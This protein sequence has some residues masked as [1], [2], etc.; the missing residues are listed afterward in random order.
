MY[1]RIE[2]ILEGKIENCFYPFFWQ[3][4]E[5][6]AVLRKYMGKIQESGMKAICIEARPHPDFLGEKWW[7][8]LDIIL[9]EARKR[10]MK[11]W[12][13]DDSHFPTGYANGAIKEKYPEHR[14][15]YLYMRRFDVAGPV[16]GARINISYLAGR[17]WDGVSKDINH[18]I[19]VYMAK[20][21]SDRNTGK[22][23]IVVDTLADKTYALKDGIISIDI[24]EGAFCIFTVFYTR[25]GGEET[26]ADYLNPLSAKATQV[27]I[28]TV[29][30]PHYEKYK[31]DFGKTI[32]G[33]F[34]DEPRFGNKKGFLAGIGQDMVLPW[35]LGLEKELPFELKFLPLLWVRGEGLEGE[36]R[37]QY[38]N[39]ITRLYHENFTGVLAKWCHDRGIC[40]LG[41]NIED[42]GAH[43]RLGYGTGHYFRGQT[44]QDF[45][46]IDVIG[47]QIV[48]GMPYHHDSF[49][50]GGCDGEFYHFALA[51][52]GSSAAHLDPVKNGRAM[53]EAFGA[54]GWNEGLKLM[55][56]ITDH[57]V[58]R[59]INYL[60]PHAFSPREFP[61]WDCPPHFYAQG[62]NPQ[63]R[64]FNVYSNYANRLMNLFQSGVHRAPAAVLYPAEQ[65]WAGNYMPVEKPVRELLEHQIDCDIVSADYLFNAVIEGNMLKIH[66][67][68]FKTVIIPYGEAIPVNVIRK[69][70]EYAKSG[71]RV[72]FLNDYP[73]RTL[74][75]ELSEE[76]W[77][78]LKQVCLAGAV[79]DLEVL[80]R[81]LAEIRLE[82]PFR[83]LV[84][85]HYD[86]GT[87]N[88]MFFNEHLSKTVD[89]I[90][91]I[92][93]AAYAYS[94]DAFS[95]TL[96]KLEKK[97]DGYRLK[98][99]PYESCVWIF[100]EDPIAIADE[101]VKPVCHGKPQQLT[102][103]WKVSFADSFS[104]PD[105]KE[106]LP[107][108][109]AVTVNTIDGYEDKCGTVSYETVLTFKEEQGEV[110]LDLGAVYEIA[111]VF[112]NNKS[113]GVKLCPPYIFDLTGLVEQGKHLLRV[114]VTN[115]LGTQI[116]DGLSQYL[117]IEPFGIEGPI[118]LYT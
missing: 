34:S 7:T 93:D 80:C 118:T 73:S 62:H 72:I 18:V 36:I 96:Y 15:W 4:G 37:Y 81:D 42:N 30:K 69:V 77:H 66:K 60:V 82:A 116:R 111:E 90:I 71:I 39:L 41:H 22:E 29:Y 48:P 10:D 31:N 33:F 9:D 1:N 3:H 103:D 55:K 54:Y 58:V 5:T 59:G 104:Y 12:I 75:G 43:T 25:D 20:R 44:E 40:Y 21:I 65:E 102:A 112:V 95:N 94:Y 109:E 92:P 11:I 46:G 35:R 26:T 67:E 91:E 89:T 23:E 85:Y 61:D 17:P 76:E 98:L 24:P 84:Y 2:E 114:E 52:L 6:E 49:S 113:A 97:E 110:F 38:M 32:T 105:F 14:K 50:T 100:S 70:T 8:D 107:V 27:L 101:T 115:T 53:C 106:T 83:E 45:S 87:Q 56:W 13:L 51:K 19:G 63:F 79:N 16:K 74:G 28:D 99:A 88:W 47:T 57:L 117:V 86:Q 68:Y 108:R 64:Y 78:I